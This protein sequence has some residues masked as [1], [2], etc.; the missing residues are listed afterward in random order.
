MICLL[1]I[2]ITYTEKGSKAWFVGIMLSSITVGRRLLSSWPHVFYS[3]EDDGS[4]QSVPVSVVR[5]TNAECE[6]RAL[7]VDPPS[8]NPHGIPAHLVEN[9]PDP[10]ELVGA[11]SDGSVETDLDHGVPVNL[12]EEK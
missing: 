3:G 5:L 12:R 6:E 11:H 7:R 4:D 8:T 10:V 2:H 9:H 1:I